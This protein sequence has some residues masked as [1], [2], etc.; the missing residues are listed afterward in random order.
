MSNPYPYVQSYVNHMATVSDLAW[1]LSIILVYLAA[2]DLVPLLFVV[3]IYRVF[4]DF[5]A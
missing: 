4:H 3:W 2:R 5:G 1:G